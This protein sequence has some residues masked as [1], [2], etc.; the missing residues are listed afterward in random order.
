M[1]EEL[2]SPLV[3]KLYSFFDREDNLP[4]VRFS[5]ISS[6][7]CTTG[8]KVPLLP[9][10]LLLP[11]LLPIVLNKDACRLNEEGANEVTLDPRLTG[12]QEEGFVVL[13]LVM[14]KVSSKGLQDRVC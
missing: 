12:R 1:L 10:F 11:F 6:L 9:L 13:V 5:G 8:D 2:G 4:Q 3:T 7:V 14:C